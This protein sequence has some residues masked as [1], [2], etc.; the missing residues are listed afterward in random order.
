MLIPWNTDAPLY[1]GPWATIALIVLNTI[2][3]GVCVAVGDEGVEDWILVY[4]D[5]LHPLQWLTSNFIHADFFHLLGNMFCL[6][7]F[8]LVIEGKVGWLSFLGVYLG[9]GVAESGFEQAL[10]LSLDDGASFGASAIIYGL[11]AMSLVW[12][13][14]N[15]MHCLLIL[16]FR[17]LTFDISIMVL[18]MLSICLEIGLAFYAGMQITSA[19]L[20]LSGALLGFGLACVLL[21]T[22]L[23]DCEHWDLFAVLAGRQGQARKE[24]EKAVGEVDQEQLEARKQAQAEDAVEHIRRLVREGHAIGAQAVYRKMA[25]TSP[26]WQLAEDDLRALI[27]ALHQQKR[28]SEA[29][30]LM[31]DYLR[32]YPAKAPR[33]RLSLAQILLQEQQRPGQALRVLSKLEPDALPD[34]LKKVHRQLTRQAEKLREEG[35][36]E[37]EAHDW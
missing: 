36:L 34:P 28:W 20:H 10:T 13:P 6:W 17:I 14:K 1:H 18:A 32:L 2:V 3:F 16:G 33:M 23:V 35:P 7:G 37:L 30:P 26:G 31:V 8:G 25:D 5:G 12:A 22:N 29:V 21:K 15:D 24:H 19:V 9:L 27:Q 11:I 4:G